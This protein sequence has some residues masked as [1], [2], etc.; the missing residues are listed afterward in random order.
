MLIVEDL[1]PS[2]ELDREALAELARISH[3]FPWGW[4]RALSSQGNFSARP[5]ASPLRGLCENPLPADFSRRSGIPT[6]FPTERI[7]PVGS[8]NKP[9]REISG[10]ICGLGGGQSPVKNDSYVRWLESN[11]VSNRDAFT[12]FL[13]KTAEEGIE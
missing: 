11:G 8:K 10:A 3:R 2:P 7:F 12:N 9:E 4:R 6:V 5:C 13:N 1:N